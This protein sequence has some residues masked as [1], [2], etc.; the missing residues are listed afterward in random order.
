MC[1]LLS[2][3]SL[4]HPLRRLIVELTDTGGF[5]RLAVQQTIDRRPILGLV[6]VGD[7]AVRWRRGVFTGPAGSEPGPVFGVVNPP[8]DAGHTIT[9]LFGIITMDDCGFRIR[10]AADGAPLA[11]LPA[12]A[13]P[14]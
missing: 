3:P 8:H 13:C 11:M 12:T 5:S 7:G 10:T 1:S 2:M 4:F 9:G 6:F 14:R